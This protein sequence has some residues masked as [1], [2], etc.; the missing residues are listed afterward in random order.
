MD[1]H[2][3]IGFQI[4]EMLFYIR[5][6]ILVHAS[7]SLYDKLNRRFSKRYLIYLHKK[8][9]GRN[10]SVGIETRNQNVS[11]E[12]LSHSRTFFIRRYLKLRGYYCSNDE[13]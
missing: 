4:N 11:M 13:K 9:Q 12:L 10:I 2:R 1:A 8:N 6:Y 7:S 5:V 3:V